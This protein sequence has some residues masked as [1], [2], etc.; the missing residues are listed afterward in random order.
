MLIELGRLVE[1]SNRR[2]C[3]EARPFAFQGLA[4]EITLIVVGQGS[5]H[6]DAAK[7]ASIGAHSRVDSNMESN[8]SEVID[9]TVTEEIGG[10][11]KPPGRKT[12]PQKGDLKYGRMAVANCN[13]LLPDTD[14]RMGFARRY[15][16]IVNAILVDCGGV[17]RCS[18]VKL[19]QIRRFAAASCLAEQ[20]EARAAAGEKISIAEHAALSSETV[21][22][23]NKISVLDFHAISL[24]L[25]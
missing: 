25:G 1:Y 22:L 24:R 17:E 16:Q 11:R 5:R 15:K 13:G 2:Y 19:Q 6:A 3:I 18:E 10:A 23:S 7:S 4:R 9:G 8:M 20:L 14:G 12:K 21:R